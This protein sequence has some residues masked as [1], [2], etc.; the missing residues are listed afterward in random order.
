MPHGRFES[1][2]ATPV[3]GVSRDHRL[4]EP[5]WWNTW[6]ESLVVTCRFRPTIRARH[7][8]DRARLDIYLQKPQQLAA[9]ADASV[10]FAKTLGSDRISVRAKT[11]KR[12][13]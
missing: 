7:L 13:S 8:S 9:I 6:A 2:V 10:P 3:Y 11:L 12:D 1:R 4:I 5:E